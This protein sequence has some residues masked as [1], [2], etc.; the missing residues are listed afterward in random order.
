MPLST[1]GPGTRRIAVIGGGISGLAA[2]HLLSRG[3][4]VVLYEAERRLGGHARTV[5][6]GKRGDQPVDTG[7]I[8]FNH[9]NY[10]HLTQLFR[11]LDV[12]VAKSDM[13]FAAS[14]DGGR[15]EYALR[16]L[17]GLLAQRS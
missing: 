17:N 14:I 12:P 1:T 15:F 11:D 3:H 6:A 16:D 10:P 8:V 13:S 5:V 2:A 7:F 4:A 9:V